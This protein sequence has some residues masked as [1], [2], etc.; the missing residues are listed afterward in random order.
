MLTT[1]LTHNDKTKQNW[2]LLLDSYENQ[3]EFVVRCVSLMSISSLHV[4]SLN[5]YYES[6]TIYLHFLNNLQS[7]FICFHIYL[8]FQINFLFDCWCRL[9]HFATLNLNLLRVSFLN[10][11]I[12][13][14]ILKY[15]IS[16]LIC[17]TIFFGDSVC[18]KK[19]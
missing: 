10:K 2:V 5:V 7:P 13:L 16:V 18:W 19:D 12:I 14:N 1:S 17:T 9:R 4:I 15:F 11:L 6:T 3:F 8:F